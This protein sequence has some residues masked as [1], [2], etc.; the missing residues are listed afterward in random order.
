MVVLQRLVKGSVSVK[1]L[2]HFSQSAF[3]LYFA[4]LLFRSSSQNGGDAY[5]H[6]AFLAIDPLVAL[7]HGL[8]VRSFRSGLLWSLILL[9]PTALLGRFFCGWVCPFGSLQEGVATLR[10]NLTAR[11][12]AQTNRYRE[13]HSVKYFLLLAGIIAAFFGISLIGWLDPLVLLVRSAGVSI[14]P[15]VVSKK[16][17]AVSPPHY[18]VGL[19]VLAALSCL[20]IASL[21]LTRFWCRALCPLGALLGLAA[22]WSFLKL[23]KNEAACN[24]CGRC[25]T[26][27]Q[28]GDDP[29]TGSL[30]RKSEC[31]LCLYCVSACPHHALEFSFSLPRRGGAGQPDQ[32]RRVAV[33]TIAAGLAAG[34]A[35]LAQRAV[36]RNHRP[37]VV[38]PPGACDES[39][40][41]ARCIRCGE[42]IHACPNHALQPAFVEAGMLG[43]WS[44]I[45]AANIG[46]CDPQCVLC[47]RVCPTQAIESFTVAQKG[48]A[49]TPG[50]STDP[51]RL[52]T[53]SYDK[54]RC[55]P[56]AQETDCTICMEW[57]PVVPKA[58]YIEKTIAPDAAGRT[59][60]LNRPHIDANACIGC[61]AC[62]F[63]CPLAP[64]AVTLTSLGERRFRPA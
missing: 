50:R 34:P 15:A 24:R 54:A 64:P 63:A 13:W 33:V 25:L 45:L 1:R 48:W 17:I 26:G 59:T 6:N 42:C 20:L 40:F 39:N 27:C 53:A 12:T 22:R 58:I 19:T 44:P 8:A 55:L 2:R 37:G 28:G 30:W 49:D 36:G 23:N 3:L 16:Y 31:H 9:I 38:R 10:S 18:W 61:G 35:A 41:L 21:R 56:W 14:L 43:F 46:F 11:R 62:E 5:A 60:Q 47:S 4:L 51:I 29:L 52:G 7:V 57:C 32:A